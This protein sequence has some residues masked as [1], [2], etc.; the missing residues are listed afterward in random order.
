MTLRLVFAGT[1]E[2]AVPTLEALLAT[3]HEVVGVITRSPKRRGRSKALVPSEVGAFAAAC[4]LPVLQTD[5]PEGAEAQRWLADREA[6]LGV[7][8]AYGSLLR[9]AVLEALPLGWINLHFS[10]LPDLRGAAPVQRALLRGDTELGCSV[11]QLEAGM[12]TGPILAESRYSVGADATSG[13]ALRF[14]ALEGAPLVVD[15]VDSLAAGTASPRPQEAGGSRQVTMAPK[16]TREDGFVAFS[17]PP[18]EIVDRAR[19]VTPE[20]GAWTT[21]PGGAPMKIRGVHRGDA[22]VEAASE[23]EPGTVRAD[24]QSLSVYCVGGAVTV[25]EVAPAGKKWMRAVDW[26]RGARLGDGAHL[27]ATASEDRDA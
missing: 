10:S 23:G 25:D 14:L 11:F 13:E 22:T 7:V 3:D 26:W 8:V 1:P 17:S 5:R 12:D 18:Q 9:P 2:V 4:G 15:A 19:A 16:L 27:G 24:K 6:D 20:P 21:L